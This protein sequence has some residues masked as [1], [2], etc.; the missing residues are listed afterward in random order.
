MKNERVFKMKG[1][2]VRAER[3]GRRAGASKPKILLIFRFLRELSTLKNSS[4]ILILKD[5]IPP[6]TNTY[7]ISGGRG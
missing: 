5:I 4:V 2:A 3:K 1:H 7:V 6:A